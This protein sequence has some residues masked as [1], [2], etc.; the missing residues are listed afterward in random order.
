M[1]IRQCLRDRVAERR[2]FEVVPLIPSARAQPRS[3]W[4]ETYVFQQLNPGTANDDFA[5]EAG[6]LRRKLEGIVFG[7]RVVVGGR[8]DKSCD[9]KRLEP[10]TLEVWEIRERDDPS[11]RIFFRFVEF[12]CIAATNIRLVRDLFAVRW[13]RQGLEY[14]PE[15]RAEIVRCRTV[16]RS[17]FVTYPAHSGDHL[18][19][20]ISN[21]IGSGTF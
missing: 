21:A 20:Y 17:L 10:T 15:W 9:V 2:M 12:D 1:S 6:R 16:W 4:A 18:D 19:E 13:I 7:K 8:R 5:L 14:W 11:I 3:V